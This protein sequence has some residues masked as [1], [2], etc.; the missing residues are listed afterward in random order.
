MDPRGDTG[1][2][3]GDATRAWLRLPVV[4]TILVSVGGWIST[5]AGT[6][7]LIQRGNDTRAAAVQSD[8]RDILTRLKSAEDRDAERVLNAKTVADLQSQLIGKDIGALKASVNELRIQID[9]MKQRLGESPR[10]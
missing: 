8:I 7:W 9:E 6:T 4:L 3:S 5:S 2:P 10:R 1:E